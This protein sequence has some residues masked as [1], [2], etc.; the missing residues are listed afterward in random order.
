MRAPEHPCLPLPSVAV[1]LAG[2]QLERSHLAGCM[3]VPQVIEAQRNACDCCSG[4]ATLESQEFRSS[5]NEGRI[6]PA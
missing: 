6:G 5:C 1:L 4:E 2:Q 3:S